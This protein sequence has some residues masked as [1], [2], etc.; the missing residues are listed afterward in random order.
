MIGD[1]QIEGASVRYGTDGDRSGSILEEIIGEI[2]GHQ[3]TPGAEIRILRKNGSAFRRATA[4]GRVRLSFSGSAG[5]AQSPFTFT[6]LYHFTG[7]APPLTRTLQSLP[8]AP[9]QEEKRG[10]TPNQKAA[11]RLMRGSDL[12]A[13]ARRRRRVAGRKS[14][15]AKRTDLRA[16]ERKEREKRA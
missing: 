11:F 6:V 13:P 3:P 4:G 8:S 12:D 5:H 15:R 1:H 7:F 2:G 10:G 9:D 14:T 16:S